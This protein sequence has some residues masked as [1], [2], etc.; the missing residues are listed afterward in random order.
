M[1]L[2]WKPFQKWNLWNAV[3]QT[4]FCTF[5]IINLFT[6][7]PCKISL[8]HSFMFINP[9]HVKAG[10]PYMFLFFP[11]LVCCCCCFQLQFMKQETCV[12][13][14]CAQGQTCGRR[15]HFQNSNINL[16]EAFMNKGTD[17]DRAG[18][19]Y[20]VRPDYL[21]SPDYFFFTHARTCH[22]RDRFK[23]HKGIEKKMKGR[24]CVCL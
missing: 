9:N 17:G 7:F 14:C 8:G 16:L 23:T 18:D 12:H 4:T 3:F 5:H 22:Y 13:T 2:S 10:S 11:F 19:S 20:L 15:A 1:F 21:S 24:I 6:V